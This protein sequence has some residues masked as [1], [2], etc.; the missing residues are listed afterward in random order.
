MSVDAV[1]LWR[2]DDDDDDDDGLWVA[3]WFSLV[4]VGA[5]AREREERE[6]QS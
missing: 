3:A 6:D 5:A 4:C 1:K 2:S